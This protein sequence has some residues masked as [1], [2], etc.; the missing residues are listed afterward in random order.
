MTST[1]YIVFII[2]AA[3][4]V[5]CLIAAAVMFF[6]FN[7]PKITGQLTGYTARKQIK[8]LRN[9]ESSQ[10]SGY[11]NNSDHLDAFMEKQRNIADKVK[12][13]VKPT[14]NLY[15]TDTPTGDTETVALPENHIHQSYETVPLSP[16]SADMPETTCLET[17]ENIDETTGNL[18]S[19]HKFEIIF[20]LN[21]INTDEVI[22]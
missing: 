22:R 21:F 17:A 7:I 12:Q 6:L 10:N 1:Y 2:T 16:P 3:A 11:S 13:G 14:G 5:I 15:N 19:E 4:A 9:R 20:D 8:Q 18:T